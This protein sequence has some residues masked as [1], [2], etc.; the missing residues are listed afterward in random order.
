MHTSEH[1]MNEYQGSIQ[2]KNQL[3]RK[4]GRHDQGPTYLHNL[5]LCNLE[6]QKTC[7]EDLHGSNSPVENIPVEYNNTDKKEAAN[8]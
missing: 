4:F 8:E 1:C 5:K 2:K 7:R 3:P 6:Q